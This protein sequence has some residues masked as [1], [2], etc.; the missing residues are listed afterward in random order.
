MYITDDCYFIHI[1]KNGGTYVRHL[2]LENKKNNSNYNENNLNFFKKKIARNFFTFLFLKKEDKKSYIKHIENTHLKIK[3][4]HPYLM[5]LRKDKLEYL[6]IVREPIDRFKSIYC[7]TV[8]R[9]HREKFKRLLNWSRNNGF[10]NINID[11][12][13]DFL[14]S[15]KKDLELQ[16]SFVDYPSRYKKQISKVTFIKLKNLTCYMNERFKLKLND[17]L[18]EN[19]IEIIKNSR[20][21]DK[22]I[23]E[24]DELINW[25]TTLTS[26]S[27]S[28]LNILYKEDIQLWNKIDNY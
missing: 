5:T 9:Q 12:F 23:K 4:I 15:N 3:K 13:V 6:V 11:I 27:L 17:S 1:P 2:L 28:K 26:D 20:L 22:V 14:C 8:K 24:K 18:S 7:Q 19:E 16:K 25:D 21:A 10:S